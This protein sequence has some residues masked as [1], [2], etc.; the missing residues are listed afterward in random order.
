[1]KKVTSAVAA[2]AVVFTAVSP[3][4]GV[5]AA[6]SSSL[7]AANKLASVGVIVDQSA[8]PAD[9]RLGDNITRREMMKI[10]MQL[11]SSQGVTINTEFQGKFTDV[12]E[13][14]W[15]WKY[16]ETALDNGFIAANATFNPGRNVTKAEALKMIMNA[17]GVEKAA[18]DTASWE[19]DYVEGGV[20]AGIVESFSD[21]STESDRGWIFKSSASSLEVAGDVSSD[22]DLLD[23]L[24]GGLDDSEDTTTDDTTTGTTGGVSLA[25]DEVEI[26]LNPASA[27][28]GTQVPNVGTIKFASVDFTAGNSDVS[29]NTVELK[30]LGLAEVPSTTRVW[31][32]L[33]GKRLS[34]KASFSSERVAVT[35][36]APAYVIKAGATETLD[37]YVELNTGA[38]N[39]FQFG[40]KITSATTTNISGEFSTNS[41]R[42][43]TYTVAPVTFNAVS[44]LNTSISQSAEALEL[45][46]FTIANNDTS[47]ETRDVKLQTITLR[48]LGNGDLEDLSDIVLERNGKTVSSEVTVS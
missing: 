19:D 39:D 14:D 45:G 9:Y 11:A 5:N 23:E 41:L 37:L 16:A 40:G 15:A 31:F 29:V 32:E 44:G 35:S 38:G 24:L 48:Q 34:G 8:N 17:S 46:R 6:F 3:V 30:S 10:A 18:N 28:N 47:N 25:G 33:N 22:D 13:S 2:F 20:A 26:S 4:A 7:E 27:S 12:P 36:F 43:A 21:Y 42:T 1:M